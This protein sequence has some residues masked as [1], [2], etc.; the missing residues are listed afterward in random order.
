MANYDPSAPSDS[1]KDKD[2]ALAHDATTTQDRFD[3]LEW[4]LANNWMG[5]DIGRL[6]RR[7][8]ASFHGWQMW[9]CT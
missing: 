4:C 1:I 8:T 7:D 6:E 5:L 9:L 3:T 2:T